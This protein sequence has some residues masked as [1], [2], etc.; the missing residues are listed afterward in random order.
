MDDVCDYGCNRRLEN[1]SGG[2]ATCTNQATCV[3][4]N[5]KYGELDDDNHNWDEG[6][7]TTDPTCTEKG[8]RTYTCTFDSKHTYIEKINAT[9]HDMASADCKNPSICKNDCGYTEGE[10]LG[11]SYDNACDDTC[12]SCGEIRTPDTHVDQDKNGK[13]DHCDAPVK[14]DSIVVVITVTAIS[15]LAVGA[16]GVGVVFLI[17]KKKIK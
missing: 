1:C 3:I 5:T 15:T 11:H 13:C 10:A 16:A 7:I 6:V 4:C 8:E 9:G 12:N 14:K 2:I 17:R